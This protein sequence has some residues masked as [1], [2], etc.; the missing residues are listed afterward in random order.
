M[1]QPLVSVIIPVY[2]IEKYLRQCLDSIINQ[3]LKDIEIICVDDG[4]TDSS[5]AI[6]QEYKEKDNR[7]KVLQ[8][9]NQY[10]GVARNNGLKIAKGKYL[11]FLDSDDFFE[12][13]MLEEMYNQA[14]KDNSDIVMCIFYDF[15][16]KTQQKRLKNKRNFKTPF[17]PSKMNTVLF[18][19]S[20]LNAWTK[21][22]KHS[23][24]IDYNLHFENTKC[25]N[26][27]TCVCTA[28]ALAKRIS[29]IN[30]PFVYYRINQDKSLTTDRNKSIDSFLIAVQKLE[31]NL[32][33]YNL[34]DT[35]KIAFMHRAKA[36]FDWESSLCT[37]EQKEQR[38]IVAKEI[39][40][41]D[42]YKLLY[43][44]DFPVTTI[45]NSI[46]TNKRLKKYF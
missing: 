13:N 11:S 34:Y 43:K 28:M 33:Y 31:D 8:Q 32:K 38:K 44:E 41:K 36:S 46:C 30:K 27:M 24:F 19:M 45:H 3:T 29:I 5:L 21:L 9:Q 15:D 2:N 22:F 37:K 35:F 7:I 16:T 39:L 18:E 25:C 4:S 23:L 26:D 17:L 14:E 6:L 42:L 1:N 12:L 40:S 10:A 20:S